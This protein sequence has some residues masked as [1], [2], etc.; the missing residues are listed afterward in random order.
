MEKEVFEAII[1]VFT[2]KFLAKG[3]KTVASKAESKVITGAMEEI[4]AEEAFTAIMGSM[5]S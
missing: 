3:S 4:T 2:T 5:G 1:W